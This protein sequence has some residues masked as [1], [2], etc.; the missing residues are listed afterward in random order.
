MTTIGQADHDPVPPRPEEGGGYDAFISY[1]RNDLVAVERIR[2]ELH[3]RG[4]LVWMDVDY[5]NIPAGTN[6][7]ERITR[8]IEACKAFIFVISQ[9]S[10]DSAACKGE[11][12][13]A[14]EL[15]K[16]IIPI[17][18]EYVDPSELPVAAAQ[19]QWID[20]RAGDRWDAG[21]AQLVDALESDVEWRDEHTR[22]AGLAR[23]WRDHNRDSSFLLR[24]SDLSNAEAWLGQQAGHR[25]QPTEQQRE[26]IAISRQGATRR[27]RFLIA[28][29]TTGLVIA[30]ALAVFALIQRASAIHETNLA[31]AQLR[32]SQALTL[33]ST[34]TRLAGSRLDESL[35]LALEANRLEPSLLQARAI[36]TSDLETVRTAGVEAVLGPGGAAQGLNAVAYSPNGE[37]LAAGGADG[38]VRIYDI[39]QRKLVAM[40]PNGPRHGAVNSVAFAPGG[41]LLATGS[42]DG[43]VRLFT[44]S[45]DKPP[46]RPR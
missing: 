31:R 24:G 28:A 6:W 43:R 14:V 3:A 1:Q 34:A 46:T 21:I 4:K 26:Y 38:I 9:G 27:Q 23:E 5:E 35:L 8:G 11:L 7:E 2:D 20:L 32:A 39:R 42:S 15:H 33:A 37:L 30:T 29:L 45:R 19:T 17:V 10:R 22:Y 16:L 13:D 25:E 41:T 40:L 36:M 44:V 12:A 18:H